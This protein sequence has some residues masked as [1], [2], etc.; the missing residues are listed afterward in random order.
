MRKA[1]LITLVLLAVMIQ[2]ALAQYETDDTSRFSL[3]VTFFRPSGEEMQNDFSDVWVGPTVEYYLTF[4]KQQRPTSGFSAAILTE[5]GDRSKM[6]IAPISYNVIRHFSPNNRGFYA[7][8]GIAY[9]MMKYEV[10]NIVG[11]DITRSEN[12]LGWTARVGYNLSSNWFVEYRY[13]AVPD[14]AGIEW[15]GS[16]LVLGTRTYF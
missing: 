2:P 10:D 4:D 9:Y 8:A 3:G 7:G 15:G 6:R 1:V 5:E 11:A 16:E 13:D 12:K 14:W